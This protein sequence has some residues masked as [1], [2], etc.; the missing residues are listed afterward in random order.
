[1]NTCNSVAVV[2]IE[3][4]NTSNSIIYYLFTVATIRTYIWLFST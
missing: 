4:D 2:S 1:M 3:N